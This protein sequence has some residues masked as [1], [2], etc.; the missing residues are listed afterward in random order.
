MVLEVPQTERV[1]D[2][3][4]F[5]STQDGQIQRPKGPNCRHPVRQKCTN[6]LPVDP[7]DEEYLK[8]KDIKHMSFHAHVRK[9]LGS[10]GKGTT[11]KKPLENFRCSLKPNCDAHKPFPKGICTKCKPQVV[12]LNRQKFRHVDNIQIENQELVNQF[13]DY[14][15]LSGH[16]RVGFLI[17]QYQP[18]LEV[19]LGIKATVAAIYEPPQHCREDG[20]EFLE[21]KNQK[22]I[23]NLLEMLG[24]QRVGWIFTDCWTANSAEGT[25]H[26][27]RHKDSFFLS[28]EECITAAM[29]QNQHPN[30]TEYSMDRHYGSKFVT[31]VASGDESMHVNFHGYQV[32]N[33]CAAMVE[34]DILCPTLYTPEL[35][36]VRETPLSEEHYI[37]DV[38]FSM[39]NEYGAEVMKNGRPLPVEYLLVDV[40][41]GMPKEPHYTFHVGTSNKS[42]SA[43]FNVENRQAIGQLQ[44]GANLIQYSS[45]FSK[46]QFLEQ[47]TNFH[48]LLYLVTND[49][50]QISDEWM[51]RLCDAVKAQDR[52]TAME[53]AQECEDWHQLM[54]LAHANGGSGN[55]VSDIPVIPNGDPFSGSSSGGSGGAVWNCGHCTFQN[56]AARQDCS[57]CGLPAAD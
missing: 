27:T 55:D 38:Q 57:M 54:A 48:F 14:W 13:L 40:P 23:D 11:L 39:K 51:K 43:K 32:S 31:V 22:T 29:L 47:A 8:E 26:Y 12:T 34:A 1:N 16:Q 33:Q 52:G 46:N 2:V 45:E 10:Q 37:T 3:D 6:C 7:F 19:P 42:K 4:V 5:L 44:G 15:R 25:V 20:I 17:G 9:L 53:W 56:E 41:A 28:A 18:H 50:V 36:Y 30:I 21:D 49:Q 35:A 24:L